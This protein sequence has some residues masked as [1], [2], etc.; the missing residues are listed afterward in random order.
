MGHTS[1]FS[2]IIPTTSE[3]TQIIIALVKR[4]LAPIAQI[5]APT[6][7]APC[8]PVCSRGV[9]LGEVALDISARDPA[10]RVGGCA[11]EDGGTPFIILGI[12]PVGGIF[13][14]HSIVVVSAGGGLAIAGF[15]ETLA[16]GG[17]AF[18]VGAD[19]GE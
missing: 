4:E 7:P 12:V 5:Y 10:C 11:L 15:D 3:T 13:R 1:R 17:V 6:P 16:E 9:N 18:T 14:I 2:A 19:Y 8:T